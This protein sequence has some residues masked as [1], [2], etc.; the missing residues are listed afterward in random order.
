MDHLL[1]C[2]QPLPVAFTHGEGVWLWDTDNN[3]YLDALSGIAVCSLGHA[4]PAIT[5][6]IKE[7]AGKLLHTSNVYEIPYQ[8]ELATAIT[9]YAGLQRAFFCNSGAEANEAAIKLARL[10]GHTKEFQTPQ[11]V[12]MEGSFHG[13]TLATLTATA[14]RK[15]QAGFEPLVQG[16]VRVPFDD[17]DALHALSANQ[18]EIAAV[19]IEPIQGEGG[20]HVPHKGYLSALRDLCTQQEWLLMLD[21]VQTGIGRTGK[22]YAYQHENI[23]PD[24]VTS[25][26]A[27]GNGIPIGACLTGPL[28]SNL[29]QPGKHATTFGGNP[30]VSRVALT[31]LETLH[32]DNLIENAA[33]QGDYLIQGI[34]EAFS[35]NPH[36]IE[37]RGHGLMIGI[38]LDCPARPLMQVGLAQGLLF[39]TAQTHVIRLLPPLI[40]QQNEADEIIKRL[41]KVISS[42]N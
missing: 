30:M 32:E 22:F 28:A 8:Q 9:Q 41:V 35:N 4:H 31:V 6:V 27:L 3:K 38:E 26:K 12:V 2:Y 14:S 25:A 7:Q 23:L 17:L 21:E 15:A 29:F 37:I 5:Q 33:R 19:L 42:L 16:F 20:I 36:V 40:L 34:Q 13:R 11:I 24:V 1:S 18:N 10:Y 39:N